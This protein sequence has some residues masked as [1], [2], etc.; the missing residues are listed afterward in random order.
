MNDDDYGCGCAAIILLLCGLGLLIW[1]GIEVTG[2][3]L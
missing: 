2:F 3:K 1:V